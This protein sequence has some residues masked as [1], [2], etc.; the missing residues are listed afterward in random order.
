MNQ[1]FFFGI[2]SRSHSSWYIFIYLTYTVVLLCNL[3][4]I[5]LCSKGQNKFV[6]FHLWLMTYDLRLIT[7][8]FFFHSFL[9][10][11]YI[12]FIS[13]IILI[14]RWYILHMP[15]FIILVH[16]LHGYFVINSIYLKVIFLVFEQ[17]SSIWVI[18][19]LYVY[20][21]HIDSTNI[22]D[23]YVQRDFTIIA[24]WTS[25]IELCIEQS[26]LECNEFVFFISIERIKY[27][28][29]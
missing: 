2:H 17:I 22:G 7:I 1:S 19:V 13:N 16:P 9:H 27:G 14:K 24:H 26:M 23:N 25:A 5:N 10:Q 4:V 8:V 21:I 28:N 29:Q 20:C 18:L 15:F 11:F 6:Q 3:N 12:V